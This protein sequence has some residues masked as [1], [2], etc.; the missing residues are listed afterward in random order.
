M[1]LSVFKHGLIQVHLRNHILSI[2]G[3]CF[4]G[5]ALA[6]DRLCHT[7]ALASC[8]RHPTDLVTQSE[9]SISLHCGF[10]RHPEH[11]WLNGKS[12]GTAITCYHKLGDRKYEKFILSHFWGIRRLKSRC[13]RAVFPLESVVKIPSSLLG[14][15]HPFTCDHIAPISDFFLTL[16]SVWL[17]YGLDLKCPQRLMCWRPGPHVQ[18]WGFWKL[19]ASWGLWPHQWINPV[20]G[21]MIS[22]DIGKWWKGEEIE[23]SWESRSLGTW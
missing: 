16:P 10:N 11:R 9:E 3:F 8:E 2:S 4:P 5:L 20:M 15:Q 19:I 12:L 13:C 18:R 23:L 21:V 6:S 7:V 22:W 17:S 14:H 1:D